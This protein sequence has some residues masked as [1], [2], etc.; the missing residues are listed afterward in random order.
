MG[1][2]TGSTKK[3]PAQMAVAH[4][5]GISKKPGMLVLFH[6]IYAVAFI[7]FFAANGRNHYWQYKK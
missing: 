5:K 6:P 1:G 4:K 3:A 7:D 2:R